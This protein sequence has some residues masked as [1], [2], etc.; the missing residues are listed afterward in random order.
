MCAFYFVTIIKKK[1]QNQKKNTSLDCS[2][3]KIWIWA[4]LTENGN[5]A[6][7]LFTAWIQLKYCEKGILTMVL[8]SESVLTMQRCLFARADPAGRRKD[9]RS[10]SCHIHPRWKCSERENSHREWHFN[11]NMIINIFPKDICIFKQN[12]RTKWLAQT[13][14]ISCHNFHCFPLHW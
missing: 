7:T 1:K 6:V 5:I 14:Q 13:E 12:I 4:K 10:N 2:Q 3:Y 11:L 8:H 9:N